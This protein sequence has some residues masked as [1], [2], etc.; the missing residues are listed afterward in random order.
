MRRYYII[1]HASE[2]LLDH[3]TEQPI[4]GFIAPRILRAK[5][6][7]EAVNLGKLQ[8]FKT[9]KSDFNRDNRAG[10]P[11]LNANHISRIRNPF[12]NLKFDQELLFFRSQEQADEHL[13]NSKLALKH[14]FRI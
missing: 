9:W 7:E 11:A 2:I 1:Y 6:K 12:K 10:T 8:L 5:S 4:I 3:S 14:W 13:N